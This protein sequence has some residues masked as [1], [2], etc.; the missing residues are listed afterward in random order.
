MTTETNGLKM[1]TKRIILATAVLTFLGLV[2][3]Y[4][5][6]LGLP[7]PASAADV[8]KLDKNQ[9][10]LAIEFYRDR[11]NDLEMRKFEYSWRLMAIQKSNPGDAVQQQNLMKWIAEL[12]NQI[13]V[14]HAKRVEFENRKLELE[15]SRK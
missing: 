3:N 7:V 12:D 2:A 14:A 8:D 11:E 5:T 4:W 1:W 15:R 13:T 9:A 6:D 10:T